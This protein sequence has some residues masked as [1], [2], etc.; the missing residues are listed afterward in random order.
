[1]LRNSLKILSAMIATI[2]VVS[3]VYAATKTPK[4]RVRIAKNIQQVSI[5]GM[6]LNRKFISNSTS[7]HYAGRKRIKFNCN[8]IDYKK[9]KSKGA[10]KLV[11]IASDTGLVTFGKDKYRG[12]ILI[13]TSDDFKSCDVI[14][15]VDIESYISSLLSKEMNGTWHLEALKA[16]AVAA[17]TYAIYKIRQR[18]FAKKRGIIQFYDIE[19]SEKHQVGG[20]FFDATIKTFDAARATRGQVLLTKKGNLTE[21]F[22]HAGCG[23]TTKRPDQV[24]S[25]KVEGYVSVDCP[26]CQHSD[27]Q[28]YIKKISQKRFKEFLGWVSKNHIRSNWKKISKFII[29]PDRLKNSKMRIYVEGKAYILEK[30]LLRRYFG[31]FT[32]PS[33]NFVL[34]QD[35]GTIVVIGK[36]HGHGVGMCQL[37][38]LYMARSGRAYNEILEHYFPNHSLKK[39]FK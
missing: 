31:R 17:R 30:S 35:D 12:K 23:G 32:V 16:Q 37:G 21:T 14:N 5:S 26:F 22:F 11:E 25:N 39:I 9:L 29:A 18:Q 13:T 19:S 36:G 34:S 3:N 15:E 28:S 4:I 7:K 1:M 24:W 10:L 20:Q 2:C 6:D 8:N 33:N 27:K 38:A